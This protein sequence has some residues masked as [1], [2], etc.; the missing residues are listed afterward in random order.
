[1]SPDFLD[2]QPASRNLS[3]QLHPEVLQIVSLFKDRLQGVIPSAA[4]QK[5]IWERARDVADSLLG[6][7]AEPILPTAPRVEVLPVAA[8][9]LPDGQ[10]HLLVEIQERRSRRSCVPGPQGMLGISAGHRAVIAIG[11]PKGYPSSEE[12]GP[13]VTTRILLTDE[14]LAAEL[15][16]FARHGFE[17]LIGGILLGALPASSTVQLEGCTAQV[18]LPSPLSREPFALLLSCTDDR[19][20]LFTFRG[21]S[22]KTGG[23]GPSSCYSFSPSQ[24]SSPGDAPNDEENH[25]LRKFRE[26]FEPR[27]YTA[28]ATL[29]TLMSEALHIATSEFAEG[30]GLGTCSGV[31]TTI[32]SV[33]VDDREPRTSIL[34]LTHTQ[35]TG[36]DR[37]YLLPTVSRGQ[38]VQMP[39]ATGVVVE[40]NWDPSLSTMGLKPIG[41]AWGRE[42]MEFD[43]STLVD[44]PSDSVLADVFLNAVA[45]DLHL[46]GILPPEGFLDRA[47]VEFRA[48]GIGQSSDH[49][50]YAVLV[51]H[52]FG[53]H[54]LEIIRHCAS[55]ILLF[56]S[57]AGMAA[58][59]IADHIA[60]QHYFP[61]RA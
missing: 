32:E 49:E 17:T 15:A 57:H 8:L 43:L 58:S 13:A 20:A 5:R 45:R 61:P 59:G 50:V 7:E 16:R 30:Q 25:G 29:P 53:A 51:L 22:G 41:V 42:S 23:V 4:E 54:H 33:I 12:Q 48:L 26:F 18:A 27:R 19:Q 1:M 46:R 47:K 10:N 6:D 56:D 39:Y 37:K 28:E 21:M 2:P 34:L 14:A 24:Y 55:G 40:A 11:L 44:A 35:G 3:P 38:K 31:T 9:T 60:V 36:E 52:E